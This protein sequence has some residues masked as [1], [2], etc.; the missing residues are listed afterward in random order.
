MARAASLPIPEEQRRWL[1]RH[2]Q[3]ELVTLRRVYDRL[4][5]LGLDG[6]DPLR[7]KV[8]S[9]IRALE[10]LTGQS[11]AASAWPLYPTKGRPMTDEQEAYLGGVAEAVSIQLQPAVDHFD[12]AGCEDASLAGAVRRL[13]NHAAAVRVHLHYFDC[14]RNRRVAAG[15]PAA[16]RVVPAGLCCGEG[17]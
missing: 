13:L 6:G 11:S 2:A 7:I 14:E 12:R 10:V 8:Y 3:K 4:G 16:P 17:I 5:N 1:T 9:V 15:Y